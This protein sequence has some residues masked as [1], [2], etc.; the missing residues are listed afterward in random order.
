MM[1]R[2]FSS[3]FFT[4]VPLVPV[5]QIGSNYCVLMVISV[6]GEYYDISS[7]VGVYNY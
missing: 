2:G 1:S 4:R 6:S 5:K 3:R 7:S